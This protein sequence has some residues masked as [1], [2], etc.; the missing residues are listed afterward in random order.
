[1][2]LISGILMIGIAF[3]VSGQYFL[4]RAAMLLVFAG[5]WAAMKGVTD[6]VR[7]FAIRRLG[8]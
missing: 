4:A 2:G 3:W 8:S 1:M 5:I 7:A 6:I